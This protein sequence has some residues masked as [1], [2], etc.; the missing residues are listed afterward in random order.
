MVLSTVVPGSWGLVP[1]G[2]QSLPAAEPLQCLPNK[3]VEAGSAQRVPTGEPKEGEKR[4]VLG[5]RWGL[6]WQVVVNKEG[7]T[8]QDFKGAEACGISGSLLQAGESQGEE[9]RPPL[10]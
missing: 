3:A 1:L 10:A 5:Q 8:V 9:V 7:P 6:S 4:E 2:G